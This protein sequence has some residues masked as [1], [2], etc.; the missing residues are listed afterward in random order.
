M[1]AFA[2]IVMAVAGTSFIYKMTLF[3][4]TMAGDDVRGFGAVAVGTYLIGMVPI[5]CI[6]LWAVLTGRFHDIE[7][8]K[9]RLL[10]LDAE[11][12]RG[13]E[14]APEVARG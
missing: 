6:T 3:T 1:F 13:G 9:Y 10:E 8:P 5:V 11:I 2:V 7:R 14:L 12:D 4:F